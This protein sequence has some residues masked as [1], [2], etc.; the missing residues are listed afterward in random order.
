MNR[1]PL[2]LGL[3]FGALIGPA[4]AGDAITLKDAISASLQ[5]NPQLA[6][7]QFRRT[8]LAGEQTIAALR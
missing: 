2:A 1:F 8:A 7:Y 4:V 5:H 6:G 3:V